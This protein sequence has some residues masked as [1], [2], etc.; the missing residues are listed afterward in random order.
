M[1]RS[2]GAT[3]A[4]AAPRPGCSTPR[5]WFRAIGSCSGPAAR[6]SL[7]T[8]AQ[9]R[10]RFAATTPPRTAPSAPDRISR[11]DRLLQLSPDRATRERRVVHV[12]VER[13]RTRSDLGCQLL[14]DRRAGLDLGAGAVAD[15]QG[16]HDPAGDTPWRPVYVRRER[17]VDPLPRKRVTEVGAI[18]VVGEEAVAVGIRSGRLLVPVERYRGCGRCR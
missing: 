8:A 11:P 2:P 10:H 16:D 15:R 3:A 13:L 17:G 4:L 18:D 9:V 6:R 12:D 1:S 7:T 5:R 14:G